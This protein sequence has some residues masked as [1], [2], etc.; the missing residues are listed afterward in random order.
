MKPTRIVGVAVLVGGIT[1]GYAGGEYSTADW[2]TLHRGVERGRR[3]I[4][5]L[6][7]EI[8][9]LRIEAEA[10]ES[11]STR[12]ERAARERF[13]MLRPGEILYR[14]RSGSP[15]RPPQP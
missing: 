4:V 7:A 15:P 11:D 2:R 14:V 1:F 10:L 9:S 12:Q 5:Q 13:G 3:A 6:E 8:D